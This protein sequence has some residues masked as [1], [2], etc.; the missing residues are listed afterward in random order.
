MERKREEL[1]LRI[2]R[3]AYIESWLTAAKARREALQAEAATEAGAQVKR[4]I[5]KLDGL[6]R[7]MARLQE[8][9]KEIEKLK[10][11]VKRL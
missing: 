7:K 2:E 5:R 9:E 6:I 4:D 10:R 1:E 8:S 11:I 3:H